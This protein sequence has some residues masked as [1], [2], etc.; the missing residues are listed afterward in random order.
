MKMPV[1]IEQKEY[2]LEV[3]NKIIDILRN[4][5][6]IDI[7]KLTLLDSDNSQPASIRYIKRKI[8]AFLFEVHHLSELPQIQEIKIDGLTYCLEQVIKVLK[9]FSNNNR[10]D[11]RSHEEAI[12]KIKNNCDKYYP[13]INLRDLRK[14][15]K[16]IETASVNTLQNE[17]TDYL[18]NLPPGI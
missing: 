11:S 3:F 12:N 4:P 10:L 18:F 1:K 15:F 6:E 9:S 7:L 16:E 8:V 13:E 14:V 2:L 17:Y 5:S